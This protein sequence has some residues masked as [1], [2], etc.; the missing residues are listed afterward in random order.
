[1]ER[2]QIL[3]A[4]PAG[5]SAAINLA[6]A[7]YNVDIFEKNEDVGSRFHGDFQGLE[8]WSDKEDVLELFKGMNI[9]INFKHNP[10]LE[11]KISNESKIW[12]FR[13]KRPAFYLVKRGSKEKTLDTALKN[14]ALDLGVNIHFKETIPEN[15]ADIIAT[16]PIKNKIYAAAKGITFKTSFKNTAVGLV[17]NNAALNGYS[18]LLIADGQG[19][20]ATVLFNN[21]SNMNY[22]L[23]QTKRIF[24]DKFDLNLEEVGNMGGIGSFS[25][26]NIFKQGKSLYVGEAA[27]L[28]DFLW[29]FGIKSAVTSGYLA[30]K[31]IINGKDYEKCAE[32]FFEDKLKAG[33][34]NRYLWER[35]C[36]LDYSF[37]VDRIY[38]AKDP[39]KFLN[40]FY[41]TNFIH[42]MIY[43]FAKRYLKRKYEILWV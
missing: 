35:F 4:G 15:E 19:C 2:V 21:F 10:F 23:K 8:N 41:N 3:G 40:Y 30:A 25:S 7:G 42:K 26:E 13:C 29:G 22:Y 17:N 9:D 11:L 43:P 36:F 39:L 32:S 27:G 38:N 33:M 12:N 6:Q 18:Y 5:L 24:N 16:G 31:S 34:V 20:M 28:Q 1:M 37:I 14:Q